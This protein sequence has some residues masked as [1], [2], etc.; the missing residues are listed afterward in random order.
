VTGKKNYTFSA[1]AAAQPLSSS[2]VVD[3]N[4]DAVQVKLN[5]QLEERMLDLIKMETQR[6]YAARSVSQRLNARKLTVHVVF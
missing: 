3:A 2:A 4:M 5:S 6:T 1:S